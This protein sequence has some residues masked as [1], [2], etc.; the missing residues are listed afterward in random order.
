[1]EF[2]SRPGGSRR[3]HKKA[4]EEIP[5]PASLFLGAMLN[6]FQTVLLALKGEG[7]FRFSFH[8]EDFSTQTLKQNLAI[9][10]QPLFGGVHLALFFDYLPRLV[11]LLIVLDAVRLDFHLSHFLSFFSRDRFAVLLTL[12][13][14]LCN[15]FFFIHVHLS[16]LDY[17]ITP[18]ENFVKT[19][20]SFFYVLFL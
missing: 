19:F 1:M 7:D 12:F 18:T 20:F 17:S 3:A 2:S 5:L 8:P 13:H 9:H 14:N 6:Q 11:G 4:G 16:F 15:Q 10:Q